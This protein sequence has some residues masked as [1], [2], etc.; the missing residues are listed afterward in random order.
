ML[1]FKI[2]QQIK[3]TIL[4]GDWGYITFAA[5]GFESELGTSTQQGLVGGLRNVLNQWPRS[6][7][8]VVVV[9]GQG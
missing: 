7:K 9:L 8:K 3:L 4:Y 1:P 6:T 5:L 2:A